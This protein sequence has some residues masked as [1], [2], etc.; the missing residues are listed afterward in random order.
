M[1]AILSSVKNI[2]KSNADKRLVNALGG[3]RSEESA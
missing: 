1:P 3:L 2:Q